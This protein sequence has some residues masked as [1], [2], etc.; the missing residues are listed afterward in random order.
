M[1][2]EL[3]KDLRTQLYAFS[4]GVKEKQRE[5]DDLRKKLEL[6][7][8]HSSDEV[9]RLVDE[10]LK[11]QKTIEDMKEKDIERVRKE[12]LERARRLKEME[13]DRIRE[14]EFRFFGR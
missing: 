9:I 5:I 6:Y 10:N 13:E 2:K 11:L 8:K 14:Q 3:E 12:E 1:N 4:Q 7:E